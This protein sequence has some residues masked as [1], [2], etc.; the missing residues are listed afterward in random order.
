M[1]QSIHTYKVL[2]LGELKSGKTS[3][4]RRYNNSAFQQGYQPT[5]GVDFTLKNLEPLQSNIQIQ[6]WDI[7]GAEIRSNMTRAY[8]RNASAAIIVFDMCNDKTFSTVSKWLHDLRS[9]METDIPV[10]VFANKSDLTH[11]DDGPLTSYCQQHGIE[12][13]GIVSALDG[14]S[15]NENMMV[16]AN[17]LVHRDN[18]RNVSADEDASM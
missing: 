10:F 12:G 5:I 15:I 2:V 4:I 11:Y 18:S 7:A 17:M 14:T 8:Y 3:I 9:K 6:F 13:F 16:I 1:S